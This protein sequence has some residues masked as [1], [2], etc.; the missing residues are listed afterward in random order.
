M[1]ETF[2]KFINFLFS[3]K[4]VPGPKVEEVI[5]KE[6]VSKVMPIDWK[7]PKAKISKY[8]TIGEVITLRK[9]NRLANE[10]DGL[11]DHVKEQLVLFY[12][13][14]V[15]VVREYLGVPLIVS[16]GYRSPEYNKLPTIKGAPGS[17]HQSLGNWAA[18]DFVPV[19]MSPEAARQKMLPMLDLWG[20]RLENRGP[21][22]VWIHLDNHP[23]I[24][25]QPR[26]F[27]V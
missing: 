27:P 17:S 20:L 9:W 22:M 19:G 26:Y 15:D 11:N 7:N 6:V 25:S 24:G 21:D 4:Q 1:L 10:S 3:G 2:F 23:L 16:C 12:T 5:T 14:R 8:F 13:T 18:I